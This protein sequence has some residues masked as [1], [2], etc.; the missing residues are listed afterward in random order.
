MKHIRKFNESDYYNIINPLDYTPQKR[1]LV[2]KG[3]MEVVSNLLP[4]GYSAE[5]ATFN[6]EDWNKQNMIHINCPGR[7]EIYIAKYYDDWFYVDDY[8]P[9][10]MRFKKS[11][12]K[13][14]QLDGLVKLLQ[15]LT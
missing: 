4:K 3:D 14:D 8:I 13:C 6:D 10:H 12:Y 11:R 7:R 15:H 2:T 1:E 9:I 5:I